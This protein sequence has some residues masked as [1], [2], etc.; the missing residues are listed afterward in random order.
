VVAGS[1][2]N[3]TAAPGRKAAIQ[4]LRDRHSEIQRF[5]ETWRTTFASWAEVE[6][7]ERIAA[8][9]TRKAVARTL[10]EDPFRSPLA[11]GWSWVRED[12]AGWRSTDLGLEV[13]FVARG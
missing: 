5:N 7:A 2:L 10:F 13:R 9:F 12:P 11:E 3:A 4:L 1:I 6:R 8:P